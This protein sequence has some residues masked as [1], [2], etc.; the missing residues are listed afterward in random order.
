LGPGDLYTNTVA[1]L[2]VKGVKEAIKKS[3]GKNVLV[4]NL[5]T[6]M[7]ENYGYKATD[8]I[9]DV[10]K[11]LP[12]SRLDY[13][14]INSDK[15]I[16][17]TKLHAYDEEGAS[18]VE[19][20]LKPWEKDHPEVRIFREKLIAKEVSEKEKGD[21]IERSIIRHDSKKLAKILVKLG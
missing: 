4:M 5:M 10:N 11:Y 15:A 2:V 16:D 17:H 13:I 12:P 7:G 8:F 18:L 14:I 6:K 21:K 9:D 3:K 1:T 20:D 19:D